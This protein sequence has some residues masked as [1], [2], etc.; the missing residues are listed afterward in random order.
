MSPLSGLFAL[1][2]LLTGAAVFV[3]VALCVLVFLARPGMW[4]GLWLLRLRDATGEPR[5]GRPPRWRPQR[6]IAA[7]F[8]QW[9]LGTM[10]QSPGFLSGPAP[11]SP[12]CGRRL[13]PRQKNRCAGLFSF[14]KQMLFL[15]KTIRKLWIGA[16]A[17][18][19][20]IGAA[21]YAGR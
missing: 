9:G 7:S 3:F 18:A 14:D 5:C 8:L 2:F 21:G 15:E 16:A 6:A 12:P 20:A 11:V 1:A 13:A 4:P 17:A 19:I 10:F